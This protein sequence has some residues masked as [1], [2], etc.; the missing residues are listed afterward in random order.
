M[1]EPLRD[2]ASNA[3]K[4]DIFLTTMVVASSAVGLA[5]TYD[6]YAA[7]GAAKSAVGREPGL[8]WLR[9][10]YLSVWSMA[11]LGDWL[12]GPYFYKVYTRH[13]YGR[14]SIQQLFVVGFLSSLFLGTIVGSLA[15]R[16]GRRRLAFAYFSLYVLACSLIHVQTLWVLMLGRVASGI[17][18]SLLYSVFDSWVV[19]QHAREGFRPLGLKTTFRIASFIQGLTAIIAGL[20]S[21][22]VVG[23][24]HG[25][26][27]GPGEEF[28]VFQLGIVVQMCGCVVTAAL[29]EENFGDRAQ[30]AEDAEDGLDAPPARSSMSLGLD[31]IRDPRVLALGVVQS[32]FESSMYVFIILWT[33]VLEADGDVPLGIIFSAFMASL[34]F[35]SQ[36]FGAVTSVI[37]VGSALVVVLAAA[38]AVLSIPIGTRSVSASFLAFCAFEVCV[39]TY[40]PCMFTLKSRLVPESARTTVYN[41]FRVPM[42]AIAVAVLLTSLDIEP[43]FGICVGLLG[44]GAVAAVYVAASTKEPPQR[45]KNEEDNERGRGVRARLL[46]ERDVVVRSEADDAKS[47]T[48]ESI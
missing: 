6:L 15:D 11:C 16:H 22:A 24:Y 23:E 43:M 32:C 5:V 31:A 8:V 44:T 47:D 30:R 17:A 39:G 13:G 35:G 42:N 34:M 9:I 29:W 46:P 28:G 48:A 38:A 45:V 40:Y 25:V 14:F 18:T 4:M 3:S 10:R 36:V 37:S 20:A 26:R 7:R 21:Q 33:P 12:Q 19:R 1:C 27:G 2:C 41:F